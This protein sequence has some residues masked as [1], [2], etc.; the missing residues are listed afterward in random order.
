MLLSSSVSSNP[1][2]LL[3]QW[4]LDI[5]VSRLTSIHKWIC[6]CGIPHVFSSLWLKLLSQ[7]LLYFFQHS[8]WSHIAF[9]GPIQ[10]IVMALSGIIFFHD[11][12]PW[13]SRNSSNKVESTSIW[14]SL[15]CIGMLL[16]LLPNGNGLM[17]SCITS[18]FFTLFIFFES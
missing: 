7:V 8:L 3:F 15:L 16:L 9:V 14:F 12:N 4:T 13:N 17:R 2:F 5:T 1:N 10:P 11:L 6:Y 18:L